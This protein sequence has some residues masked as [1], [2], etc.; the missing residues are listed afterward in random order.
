MSLLDLI[1][2]ILP[3][4]RGPKGELTRE[5][6][7]KW[8]IAVAA[9]SAILIVIPA[10]AIYGGPL[11]I[12]SEGSLV[13]SILTGRAYD[14][15]GGVGISALVGSVIFLMLF[16]GSRF[17]KF[18]L[19]DPEQNRRFVVLR[20]ILAIC[21][22]LFITLFPVLLGSL[23]IATV[24]LFAGGLS[25]IYLD[26]IECKYGLIGSGLL[27]FFAIGIIYSLFLYATT[28]G[29]SSA[30]A[31]LVSRGALSISNEIQAFVPVVVTIILMWLIIW[32]YKQKIGET[33]SAFIV[34]GDN[35][36][37][38]LSRMFALFLPILLAS[39]LLLIL[40]IWAG[41]LGNSS[42][43][44]FIAQYSKPTPYI[45]PYLT[46]GILYLAAPLFPLAYPLPYGVGS[47]SA[48]L[49]YL[50]SHT[51]ALLLPNGQ[52]LAIPEMAHVIIYLTTLI[53]LTIIF[54]RILISMMGI[55]K[56][57]VN[58]RLTEIYGAN[59]HTKAKV[60]GIINKDLVALA[61]IYGATIISGSYTGG[62]LF[63]AVSLYTIYNILVKK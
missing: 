6:R 2:S 41:L 47:I 23:P 3:K 26:E 35:W 62:F 55:S 34:R 45:Q 14:A 36:K 49:T 1:D 7:L 57:K 9:I 11:T 30:A 38:P 51:S 50:S 17:F 25:L 4:I 56:E 28:I 18:D 12:S 39:S 8:T 48:Y 63:G 19:K 22:L 54:S 10:S 5:Q 33:F 37:Q 59:G 16:N 15:L 46:G 53:L 43:A 52:S 24:L 20:K 27:I 58:T 60:L 31:A 13:N 29:F 44:Q 32:I 61:L 21:L 40:P 42:T